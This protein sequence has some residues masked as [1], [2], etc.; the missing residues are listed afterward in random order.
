MEAIV[1]KRLEADDD[2]CHKD[3]DTSEMCVNIFLATLGL[4][5]FAVGMRNMKYLNK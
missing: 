4:A 1:G 5:V 3:V 2:K